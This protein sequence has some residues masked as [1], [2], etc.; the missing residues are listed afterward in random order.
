MAQPQKPSLKDTKETNFPE[1]NNYTVPKSTKKGTV[2]KVTFSDEKVPT[3]ES[4]LKHPTLQ[5]AESDN[6]NFKCNSKDLN[7]KRVGCLL[8]SRIIITKAII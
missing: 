6:N 4:A 2:L 1:E 3:P 8:G 5:F 7:S